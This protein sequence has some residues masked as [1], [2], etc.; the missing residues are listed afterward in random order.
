M[1]EYTDEELFA[2]AARRMRAKQNTLPNP[3]KMRPCP[4]GCGREFNAR[5]MRKHTPKCEGKK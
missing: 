1:S 5:E 4:K 2:E 3:P